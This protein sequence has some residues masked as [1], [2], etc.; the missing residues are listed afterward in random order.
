MGE[1]ILLI[2]PGSTILQKGLTIDFLEKKMTEIQL[3]YQ[4]EKLLSL[5]FEMKEPPVYSYQISRGLLCIATKLIEDGF[6]P[7]YLQMDYEKDRKPMETAERI[8]RSRA[9]NG[10]IAG[11]TSYTFNFDDA[12]EIAKILKSINPEIK[13]IFG[14]PHV[15]WLDL[16]PLKSP[17]IDIVVRGEGENIFRDICRNLLNGKGLDEIKGIT[18]KKDGKIV[19]NPPAPF[20]KSEEIPIPAYSLIKSI[21]NPT[22]VLETTRGCPMRCTFCAESAFWKTVRHRRIEDVVEEIKVLESMLGYNAIHICDPYF[23]ISRHYGEKLLHR[24]KEE[25]IEVYFNCNVRVDMLKIDTLKLLSLSN[26]CGFFIGIESGSDKVLKAMRKNI[27]FAEYYSILKKIRKYIPVIDS[28]WMIG[29]PGEDINTIKETK[30]KIELLLK[31]QLVDGVWSKIF[32]PYPGTA[33]F[34]FPNKYGMEILTRDWKRY[35]RN[36]FPVHRLQR[37][38]EDEMYE[39]NKKIVM[40]V[41]RWF[42]GK[43]RI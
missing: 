8:L 21:E 16:E 27:A 33:P 30:E 28:S 25:G 3:E 32:I 23:P 34:H 17:Y 39:E 36:S 5:E 10:K 12:V 26:F 15:T 29:H 7:I 4:K 42:E 35:V 41:L 43:K 20:L 38:S 19:R 40:L 13:V 14:G 11:I 24:I 37:L 1:E 31:E 9:R 2:N 18:Y 6:K 22:V